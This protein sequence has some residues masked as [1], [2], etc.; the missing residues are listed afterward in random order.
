MITLDAK[1]LSRLNKGFEKYQ[2]AIPVSIARKALREAAQPMLRSAK[3]LV[4]VGGKIQ[5]YG[6]ARTDQDRGGAT[7]RDIRIAFV[8]QENLEIARLVV[9]VSQK[10]GRVGWR[11]HFITRGFTDRGGS[12]HRGKDFLTEAH[13]NTIGEVQNTFYRLLFEGFVKWGKQNLPQ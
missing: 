7:R 4:P 9:G 1:E 2:N 11:T 6:K 5:K 10:S 13:D 3:N 8:K 12:F